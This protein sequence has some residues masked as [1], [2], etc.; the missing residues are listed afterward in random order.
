[1]T[2]YLSQGDSVFLT[3]N[4]QPI[5]ITFPL[6]NDIFSMSVKKLIAVE[7]YKMELIS[8]G[9]MAEILEI[10]KKEVMSLLNSLNIVWLEDDLET[11]ENEIQKWL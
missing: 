1:M 4:G 11:I 7:L 5:D 2:K 8:L 6:N 10:K 3:K 9:K